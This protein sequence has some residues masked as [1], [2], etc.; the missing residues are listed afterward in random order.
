MQN[1]QPQN[2]TSFDIIKASAEGYKFLWQR[3][4]IVVRLA[5]LPIFVKFI[6]FFVIVNMGLE[7]NF[8]RQGL[9]LF[10]AY[11]LEGYLICALIRIAVFSN[12]ELV[13]P[14]GSGAHE[15][16]KRR[17]L[18][19]QAGAILYAFIKLMAALLLGLAYTNGAA[20]EQEAAQPRETTFELFFATML[21]FIFFIWAFRLMWLNVPVTLG[22]SMKAYLK[23][24]KGFSFS[25]HIFSVWIM[26]IIPFSLMAILFADILFSMTNSSVEN[27]S[28][29]FTFS[30]M[31]IAAI[32]ETLT[33]IVSNVAIG[34]GIYWIMT[35]QNLPDKDKNP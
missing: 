14:P 17:G 18:D 2:S 29:L 15:Y 6:C 33:S 16:Y 10:P 21:M 35:G 1:K 26:C 25:F 31:G 23:R 24:V 3:R 13:Q 9:I 4:D 19:I 30:R 28:K 5:L 12:E 22:Y 27:P 20:L 32:L 11:L 7:T 8:L 34:F